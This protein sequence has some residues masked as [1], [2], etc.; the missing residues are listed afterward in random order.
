[1]IRYDPF[2]DPKP[3][4]NIECGGCIV[5]GAYLGAPKIRTPANSTVLASLYLGKSSR[6]RKTNIQM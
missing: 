1:V 4:L 3:P 2:N 5:S 6:A